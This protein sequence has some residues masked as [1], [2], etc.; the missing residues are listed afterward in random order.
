MGEPEPARL[1][2]SLESHRQQIE[3]YQTRD[4]RSGAVFA[5]GGGRTDLDDSRALE[6][7]VISTP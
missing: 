4:M 5:I 3:L 2:E 1:D 6:D 7:T